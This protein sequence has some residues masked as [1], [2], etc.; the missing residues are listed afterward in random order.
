MSVVRTRHAVTIRR[1][2]ECVKYQGARRRTSP[3]AW[4]RHARPRDIGRPGAR[5][6]IAISILGSRPSSAGADLDCGTV[7]FY[8]AAVSDLFNVGGDEDPA[9]QCGRPFDIS[10]SPFTAKAVNVMFRVVLPRGRWPA[11]SPSRLAQARMP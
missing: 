9:R 3:H 1:G 10:F 6:R 5:R 7:S 11:G 4:A 8:P 2:R